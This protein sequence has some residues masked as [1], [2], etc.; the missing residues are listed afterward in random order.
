MIT[1][2]LALKPDLKELIM[3]RVAGDELKSHAR[4]LGMITLRGSAIRKVIDGET[5]V[6]EMF[7][8]TTGDQD[9]ENDLIA[10]A[11]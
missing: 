5:S 1:E 9:L 6:G 7:R 8:V 4:K 3:K 11:S 2:I 10:P